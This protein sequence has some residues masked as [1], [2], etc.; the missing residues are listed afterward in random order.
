MSTTL[1]YSGFI[2][3]SPR[4][5]MYLV[6]D[7]SKSLECRHAV[8]RET[9]VPRGE[10]NANREPRV[11]CHS[12][13]TR[14]IRTSKRPEASDHGVS[15]DGRRASCKQRGRGRGRGARELVLV[16]TSGFGRRCRRGAS[17]RQGR[18]AIREWDVGMYCRIDKLELRD[19]EVFRR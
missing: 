6:P 17:Y 3:R 16:G 4:H 5:V 15:G 7:L 18:H 19:E 14:P 1:G 11:R 12:L 13:A 9:S 10:A 2:H 8:L